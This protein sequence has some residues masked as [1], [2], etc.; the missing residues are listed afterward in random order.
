MGGRTVTVKLQLFEFPEASIA[1][2][3]TVFVPTGKMEPDRGEKVFV[4]PGQ[5]SVEFAVKLTVAPLVKVRLG[6]TTMLVGQ[7]IFGFSVSITVT[8]KMQ[9]V[10]LPTP[11]VAVQITVVV[12]FEN[13]EPDG[14]ENV[15]LVTPE[16]LSVAEAL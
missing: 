9:L 6:H 7:M 12:P 3:I 8:V 15:R 11:S 5:L 14:G 2:A 16:Q 10:L 1:V 13:V 4:V